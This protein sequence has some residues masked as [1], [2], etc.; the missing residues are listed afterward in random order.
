M[1]WSGTARIGSRC[2]CTGSLKNLLGPHHG[3]ITRGL[4]SPANVRT[5]PATMP[6]GAQYDQLPYGLMDDF[7]V[8]RLK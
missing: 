3:T 4:A 5:A 1:A 6:P 7:Q 2:W 8:L